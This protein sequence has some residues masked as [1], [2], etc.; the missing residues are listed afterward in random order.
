MKTPSP[1]K[2]AYDR[3][4]RKPWR[5][6]LLQWLVSWLIIPPLVRAGVLLFLLVVVGTVGY[7]IIEGW[8]ISDSLFMIIITITTIG[9]GEVKPL[10]DEGRLFTIVL[11]TVGVLTATYAVRA[12]IETLTSTTFLEQIRNRRTIRILNQVRDHTIICGYGRMGSAL[13][14]ELLARQSPIVIIDADSEMVEDGQQKGIPAVEGSASDEEILDQAGIAR[15][16]S[17]V[18][19]T[20]TDAENVF[21]V[22][23]AR[24]LNPSLE[25]FARSNARSSIAKLEKA[26]ADIVISPYD[27]T[28]Q[29]I[30]HMLTKP[31]VTRFLDGFLQ[32]GDQQMAL[33]EFVI[34]EESA[35]ASLTL[36][37]AQL[38]VAVLAI[39]LPGQM[40]FTHPKAETRLEPGAAI[41]V[42][43]TYDALRQAEQRIL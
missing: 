18:A 12:T 34:T 28:G 26:G 20:R 31:N 39:D 36:R 23:T 41:V 15:A 5:Q 7:M 35:V 9:Y 6:S 14:D 22:L 24:G 8:S 19:A 21:I 32:F 16:K 13:A 10:T 29:R 30:A 38:G 2:R 37:E 17:L 33:E 40:V 4:D 43:G 27:I 25:I 42:M 11:I 3:T 1:S